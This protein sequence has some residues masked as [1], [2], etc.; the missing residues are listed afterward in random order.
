MKL[1]RITFS[2]T[3]GTGRVAELLSSAFD[4]EIV[5]VDLCLSEIHAEISKEDVCIVSVP[6]YGGR[7]PSIAAGRIAALNGCGAK[8]VLVA[9]YGNRAYEDTLAELRDLC[10]EAGFVPSA[11]V[12]AIAEHS[13]DRCF[14]AGRPDASDAAELKDFSEKILCALESSSTLQVPGNFPY[15]EFKGSA[16]KPIV[17]EL[18]TNCGLCAAECPSGAISGRNTDLARCVSCMRCIARCP[19][20][21]R[22]LHPDVEKTVHGF[23]S[24]VASVRKNNELFL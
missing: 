3:G 22:K 2:P 4:C 15:K 20:G 19:V 14:A 13:I 23:L 10:T 1:F 18:C 11:A 8:A 7:I 5:D 24:Q 21:A 16:A 9:V 6:S 17:S 12:A